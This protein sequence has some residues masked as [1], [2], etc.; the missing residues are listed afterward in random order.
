MESSRLCCRFI[1]LLGGTSIWR[2][3]IINQ[4]LYSL[5]KY[6]PVVSCAVIISLMGVPAIGGRDMKLSFSERLERRSL[7][8]LGRV[9]RPP[10]CRCAEGNPAC[11]RQ[12]RGTMLTE[13]CDWQ[14]IRLPLPILKAWFD[15]IGHLWRCRQKRKPGDEPIAQWF[16]LLL[17]DRKGE[18]IK[19]WCWFSS[20]KQLSGLCHLLGF[21]AAALPELTTVYRLSLTQ[22]R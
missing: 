10:R 17:F 8:L 3:V 14:T 18:E 5:E 6:W 1:A 11:W 13:W 16:V 4:R 15:M 22:Q 7:S 9:W 2:R 21:V 20:P 19:R 12:T